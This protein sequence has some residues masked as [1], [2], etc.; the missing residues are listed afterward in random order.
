MGVI[1]NDLDEY[2]RILKILN[3]STKSSYA[4]IERK[5]EWNNKFASLE[6]LDIWIL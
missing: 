1:L 4:R 5:T 3:Y 2:R 6:C